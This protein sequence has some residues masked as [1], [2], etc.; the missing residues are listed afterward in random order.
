MILPARLEAYMR[1]AAALQYEVLEIP[2]F[3]LFFKPEDPFRFFNY[4]RPA[5]RI[6]ADA[7]V[8][9]RPDRDDGLGQTLSSALEALRTAF[10]ARERM[11][12]FEFVEEFA[13]GL[14]TVLRT[15]GFLEEACLVLMTCDAESFR[16]APGV[17]GLEMS[18][19]T[20]ESSDYDLHTFVTVQRQSFD[21]GEGTISELSAAADQEDVTDY[22]SM[23]AAG[24]R[25]FV[26]RLDGQ[27]AGAGAFTT[28]LDGLTELVG[29][30]TLPM[31]RGRG[32]GMAITARAAQA[33]FESGV[34]VTF[35]VAENAR[36]GRVYERVGFRPSA[37]VLMYCDV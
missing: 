31:Y 21:D 36:A 32:I 12:R 2:P 26:A 9:L 5:E 25:A 4:A 7:S 10:I 15:A 13:P 33:A 6:E 17:P 37:S 27:P 20:V 8:V 30:G 3:I 28:P 11:P 35:L 18:S 16:T 24:S 34:E 19:L 22:R 23:L 14:A 1:R 29:I